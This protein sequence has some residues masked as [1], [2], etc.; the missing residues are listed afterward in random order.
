MAISAE[1]RDFL[2]SLYVGYF[3]RAPDPAGLQFWID[4]VEA[5]RDTNTIAA[6][7]AA[8]P[9]A[10][11]LYPF[12]T[13]PDVSSPTSFITAVYANLFNRAPDAAGQ[14]FW[15]QQLSSGAVSPADAI[16]AIIKGATTA[17][18]STILANK[19]TVGL[20][21]ATDAGNTPG[22]T[23]DLNGASGNAAKNAISGVTEDAATVTAAQA[24]TDAY[25]NGTANAGQTITLTDG[26]DELVGTA[27]N[28]TFRAILDGTADDTLTTFD[29]LD[30][31]GGT[32]TFNLLL[33]A[34]SDD[35]PS[36]FEIANI[37]V[38]NLRSDGTGTLANGLLAD[39]STAAMDTTAFTDATQVWQVNAGVA[40]VVAASGVTV[41][42]RDMDATATVEAADGVDA[43]SVA[44]DTADAASDV[45][46]T[47]ATSEDVLTVSVS[48]SITDGDGTVDVSGLDAVET[49][50][51]SLSED[52]AIT[53]TASAN[54]TVETVDLSGSTGDIEIDLTG[55]AALA[56]VTGGAAAESV[57]VDVEQDEDTTINVAGGN[58]TVVLNGG[59][60]GANAASSITLGA[61]EDLLDVDAVSNIFDADEAEFE[62][63][64]ITIE[65]FSMANDVLDISGI[66]APT[67]LTNQNL[68]D[69][70]GQDNLFDAVTE[71]ASILG[72]SAE[73]VF[74]YDG[75]AYYFVN[76]TDAA[77]DS[78]D[79]LIKLTGVSIESFDSSNYVTA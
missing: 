10:K 50:N 2:V 67:V 53:Y 19:N 30:G 1:D 60:A 74:D 7:F 72:A 11:S 18:D 17:P 44:L 48:G 79:G 15:E 37:E 21:F 64:L 33:E 47:E 31:A 14:A 55:E 54:G 61:G 58:D 25:L 73:A 46:L 57:T 59:G 62:S 20:D 35:L 5:G 45:A 22:F 29:N 8:S 52:G 6:D 71:A 43:L 34:A 69:I 41:G 78:G 40:N 27:N 42:F 4:Q 76:D 38:V 32:D 49:V 77:F 3:N 28:D 13:T 24:A 63:G 39:G 70:A 65:D 68:S 12:L 66:G 75:D 16:D 23:F 56:T 9:E 51:L 26:V 36:G